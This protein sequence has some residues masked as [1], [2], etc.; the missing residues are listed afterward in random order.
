[1]IDVA[2]TDCGRWTWRWRGR[3]QA[4]FLRKLASF[5]RGRDVVRTRCSRTSSS[6]ASSSLASSILF[7]TLFCDIGTDFF[8]I[9]IAHFARS[10]QRYMFVSM[11]CHRTLRPR[12]FGALANLATATRAKIVSIPAYLS[13]LFQLYDSGRSSMMFRNI[14]QSQTPRTSRK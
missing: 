1:M 4:F 6:R 3:L 12:S 13:R 7:N 11:T 9:P 10:I 2:R 8:C 5:P 14:L